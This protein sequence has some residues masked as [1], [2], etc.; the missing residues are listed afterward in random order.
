MTETEA[1]KAWE[2]YQEAFSIRKTEPDRAIAIYEA[3][4]D[5]RHGPPGLGLLNRTYDRVFK[6]LTRLQRWDRL[7]SIARRGV[8][9]LPGSPALHQALGEALLGQDRLAEAEAALLQVIALDPARTEA[10]NLLS[11]VRSSTTDARPPSPAR[12]WPAR[13]RQFDNPRKTLE[14]YVLRGRPEDR[15][16]RPGSIFMTMGSCFAQNL[17]VRLRA[18]GHACA[19]EPIGEDVNSTFAN[20]TMLRWVEHGVVDEP[21]LGMK[22]AFG[23]ACRKRLRGAIKSC[24]I[25]VLSLGVAA[26]FFHRDTNEFAFIGGN[27]TGTVRARLMADYV[28]RTTTV[29]QNVENIH[30]ILDAIVR[31]AGRRPKVVLTVSPVA[32]EGTN[33]F[34]S[35]PVADCLSKS[36]LRLAAQE[37]LTARR[38]EGVVYWPSFEMVRWLG[39]HYG[40]GNPLVFGADDANTHHVSQ[41]M[42]DL[43]IRLFL[44][45]HSIKPEADQAGADAVEAETITT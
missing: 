36:T 5:G 43:V 26:S 38:D 32:L 8:D 45:H 25:F 12:P 40:P 13:Q 44:E 41:W 39:P 35:A 42:V 29:A 9:R 22:E 4:I 27:V 19:Y 28:M 18:S 1:G 2:H 10:R 23:M 21:T 20:R 6:L 7:E 15:F 11:M 33:E 31:I 37:V 17:A 14:Q 34:E 30:A 16:I 3:I 24:D